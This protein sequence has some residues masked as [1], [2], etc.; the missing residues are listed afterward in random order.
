MK[1]TAPG[2]VLVVTMLLPLNLFADDAG[3]A[4]AK[5]A[6][7]QKQT[8]LREASTI[9]EEARERADELEGYTTVF[10]KQE[11]VDGELLPEEEILMKVKLNPRRIYMRWIGEEKKGQEL[12]WGEGWNNEE[13]MAH[14]G[15]WFSFVTVNL[16]PESSQAMKDNRHSVTDA[17]FRHTV[18]LIADDLLTALKHPE[19]VRKVEDLGEKK[20]DGQ[21]ARGFEAWLRKDKYP[22]F[23]GYRA[24]IWIHE[25]L[26]LPVRIQIWDKVDDAIR[27]VE[28][29]G[30]EKTKI[31]VGLSREDFDPDNP[32]Y[33]F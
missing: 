1:Y 12:L 22:G 28:N 29:Y 15:G 32:E 2:V 33:D 17:G 26:Y 8:A 11:Y 24:R 23:Y 14:R 25:E 10:H 5:E 21:K 4:P 30:Y 19:Y 7:G 6:S 16:D 18:N 27:L 9:M 3:S 20:I 31:N 13:I